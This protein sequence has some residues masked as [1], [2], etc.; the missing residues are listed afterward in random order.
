MSRT[1]KAGGVGSDRVAGPVSVTFSHCA[2][3][4]CARAPQR[5]VPCVCP[6]VF[7]EDDFEE[8]SDLFQAEFFYRM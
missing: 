2:G 7:D 1:Q 8:F 3:R 5:H 4:R 6:Q